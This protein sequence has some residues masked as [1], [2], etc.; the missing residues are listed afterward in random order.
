MKKLWIVGVVAASLGL[1]AC[2]ATASLNDAVS[3]L[4]ASPY[5]QVH[6][7]GNAAGPDSTAAQQVL[8]ALSVDLSYANPT[9]ASLADS[10]GTANAEIIVNA[11]GAALVDIR[12]VD[13]NVYAMFNVSA[14]SN[15]PDETLP[16]TETAE[17]QLLFGGRWFEAPASLLNS[18]VPNSAAATATATK[19]R[20][21]GTKLI[22][23]LTSL[24]SDTSYT[25]LASGGYSQSG[26]LDSVVKAVWPTI[27]AADNSLTMPSTVPGTYAITVTTS[28][29]T[30]T[31]G[32][33]A[34]TA[35]DGTA[36]NQTV[37]LAATAAHASDPIVAPTGA[38][39]ITP[40]LL[41]GLLAQ[42][43]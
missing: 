24:I 37:S 6:L 26:T 7:S 10:Q 41:K 28:G 20:A 25:T 3:S 22:D 31:G 35:P 38:T 34:I 1:S 32:S 4:G 36:G 40:A 30:A 29:N 8:G 11:G 43:T 2:G 13:S 19:E 5:L 18:Y 42:A 9:G 21:L 33:I 27:A 39:I 23:D 14:L 17:L 15:I 12:V 16:A